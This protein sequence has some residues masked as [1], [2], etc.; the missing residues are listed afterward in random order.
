M[1]SI[2]IRQENACINLS[3]TDLREI[4]LTKGYGFAK[5]V[6]SGIIPSKNSI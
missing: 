1:D 5:A 6:L 3:I 4:L 2:N